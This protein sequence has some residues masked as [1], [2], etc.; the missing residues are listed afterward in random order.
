M[1]RK[2][3]VLLLLGIFVLCTVLNLSADT[4]YTSSGSTIEGKILTMNNQAVI[5]NATSGRI[6]VPRSRIIKIVKDD[7]VI[8]DKEKSEEMKPTPTTIIEETPAPIKLTPTPVP[9]PTPIIVQ[10]P[11]PSVKTQYYDADKVTTP[12][13]RTTPS[14]IPPTPEPFFQKKK[15]VQEE[16]IENVSVLTKMIIG[17]FRMIE[18][19]AL[20]K[21]LATAFA[22]AAVGDPIHIKDEIKTSIG[23]VIIDL[24]GRGE[25]RLPANSHI[26]VVYADSTN[27]KVKIKLFGGKIW[28][29]I[30]KTAAQNIDF[31]VQTPGVVAGVRGTIFKIEMLSGNQE[32]I[33]VLE[34]LVSVLVE[35]TGEQFDVKANQACSIN[36][37]TYL[38]ALTP[39]T[40]EDWREWEEWD[41]WVEEMQ[42][43]A[44][45]F[46]VGGNVIS[47]MSKQIAMEQKYY[48]Q[49]MHDAD[50]QIKWNQVGDAL[51]VL[52]QGTIKFAKDVG[53]LPTEE[54]GLKALLEDPGVK[55]WNGPYIP[56]QTPFPIMDRWGTEIYYE[57]QLSPTGN[58]YYTITSAGPNKIYRKG[59]WQADED[60]WVIINPKMIDLN[61]P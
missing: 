16:S 49:M 1:Y 45:M 58:E 59:K 54:E 23:K 36:L 19:E 17:S 13:P 61:N 42:G 9:M 57:K 3:N 4:L 5:I 7:K 40:E 14:L 6:T 27:S 41:K 11:S 31:Q 44:V 25:V 10:T 52:K 37:D 48:G 46:P 39:T 8:E 22:K 56:P 28:T 18:K 32:R 38:A 60:V 21:S 20:I 30:E 50:Q 53:R 26:Q 47:D 12:K 43:V 55:K 51:E 35:K 33:A 29:K 34:G 15:P 24:K 2:H